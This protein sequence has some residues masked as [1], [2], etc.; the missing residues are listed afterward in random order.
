MCPAAQIWRRFKSPARRHT[1]SIPALLGNISERYL[2]PLCDICWLLIDDLTVCC[3]YY[4][5]IF[6]CVDILISRW[7]MRSALWVFHFGIWLD[8]KYQDLHVVATQHLQL[9]TACAC[10]HRGAAFRFSL[11]HFNATIAF[12]LSF[13]SISKWVVYS[14]FFPSSAFEKAPAV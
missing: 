10:L 6:H 14:F 1:G 11:L 9:S 4:L 12:L 3:I 2:L 13:G 7:W 5:H 8:E